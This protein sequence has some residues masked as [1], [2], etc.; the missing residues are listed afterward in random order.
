MKDCS[1]VDVIHFENVAKAGSQMG[2]GTVVAFPEYVDYPRIP[3][4]RH[5]PQPV[6]QMQPRPRPR[7]II[8]LSHQMLGELFG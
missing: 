3:R 6:Q 4:P 7:R 5:A 2:S 1:S 8:H